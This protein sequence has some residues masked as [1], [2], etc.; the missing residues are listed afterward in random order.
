MSAS[1]YIRFRLHPEGVGV[2]FQI[3]LPGA[4]F[5]VLVDV[6]DAPS[7]LALASAGFPC[8]FADS[9][10]YSVSP[11]GAR[12]RSGKPNVP[13]RAQRPRSARKAF[14]RAGGMNAASA[15]SSAVT[16]KIA[17]LKCARR[18]VA[19]CNPRAT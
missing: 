19:R 2:T 13:T 11:A 7:F 9:R 3:E 1:R 10:H 6:A 4:R 5:A 12:D 8:A 15:S 14:L 17:K 18:D 16:F